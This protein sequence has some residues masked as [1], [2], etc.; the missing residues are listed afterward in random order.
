MYKFSFRFS[1]VTHHVI[2]YTGWLIIYLIYSS[3]INLGF[4]RPRATSYR[5]QDDC[6]NVDCNEFSEDFDFEKNLALFD[7]QALYDEVYSGSDG[8]VRYTIIMQS[9]LVLC[10]HQNVVIKS[11]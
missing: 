11:V 10:C 1:I 4:Q 9:V 8:E 2:Y 6:F 5:N 3:K 7:K